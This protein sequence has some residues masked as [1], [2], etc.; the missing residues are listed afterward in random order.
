MLKT[1]QID[2]WNSYRTNIRHYQHF[3][4]VL[5]EC[6]E[7]GGRFVSHVLDLQAR[8]LPDTD[9]KQNGEVSGV[10]QHFFREING[11]FAQDIPEVRFNHLVIGRLRT[12]MS[13]NEWIETIQKSVVQL[14]S[15]DTY[16]ATFGECVIDKLTSKNVVRNKTRVDRHGNV[17]PYQYDPQILSKYAFTSNPL[18]F[19]INQVSK[20]QIIFMF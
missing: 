10:T 9:E 2:L 16:D 17:I 3:L 20:V 7:Y 8:W 1:D 13:D 12:S 4:K 11:I 19:F 15:K 5:K 6:V 14:S 18:R